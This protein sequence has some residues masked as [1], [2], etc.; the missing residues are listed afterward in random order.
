MW[1]FLNQ[2]K[3]TSLSIVQVNGQLYSHLALANVVAML[4]NNIYVLA[5]LILRDSTP[6]IVTIY[7]FALLLQ[8]LAVSFMF[9]PAEMCQQIHGPA[10]MFPRVQLALKG[11]GAMVLKMK[12]DN[13]MEILVDGPK[14]TITAGPLASFTRTNLYEV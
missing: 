14:I 3:T 2:H 4:P 1:N 6:E 7:S 9:L 8:L 12:Y 11:Y 5:S 13:L 10:K